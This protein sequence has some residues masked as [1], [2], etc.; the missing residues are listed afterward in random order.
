MTCDDA[1]S[2]IVDDLT[3]AI[4]PAKKLALNGHLAACSA[5]RASRDDLRTLWV[6]LGKLPVPSVRPDASQ[7]FQL[8]AAGAMATQAPDPRLADSSPPLAHSQQQPVDMTRVRH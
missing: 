6:D 8:A 4:T 5:C 1:R 3:Q 7:R 2:L